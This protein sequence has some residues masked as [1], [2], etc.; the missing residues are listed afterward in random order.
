MSI[1]TDLAFAE[2]RQRRSETRLVFRLEFQG[3]ITELLNV[4]LMLGH[5][6]LKLRNEC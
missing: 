4:E 3:P 5:S 6:I 2:A 1:F